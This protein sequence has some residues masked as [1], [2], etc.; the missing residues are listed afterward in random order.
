MINAPPNAIETQ[1]EVGQTDKHHHVHPVRTYVAV[2]AALTILTVT[3]WAVAQIDLGPF[4]TVIALAI[5]FF[6]ASL[7]VWFFM[8][9]RHENPLTKL[10]ALG[11]LFWLIL[12]IGLTLADYL[13][14]NWLLLGR[15]Y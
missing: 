5:A 13:T 4:N 1:P 3:T 2:W 10:F 11:G 15:W 8:D 14:R 9:L 7:V 6:K 12:L